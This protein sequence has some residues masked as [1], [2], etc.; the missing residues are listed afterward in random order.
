MFDKSI[1][2]LYQKSYRQMN[3]NPQNILK[4]KP[5]QSKVTFGP[6]S[7]NNYKLQ[8]QRSRLKEEK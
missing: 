8:I 7:Q 6:S 3:T 1:T 2:S 4:L 5:S